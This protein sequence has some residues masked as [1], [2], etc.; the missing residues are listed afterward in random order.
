LENLMFK[1]T[2]PAS[3]PAPAEVGTAVPTEPVPLSVLELD[4]PA[5]TTGWLIE[6]DRRGVDVVVDDIGRDSISKADARQLIAEHRDNEARKARMRAES[7][8]RAI[9]ADQRFRA[10]L[11]VGVPASAIPHGMTY[12]QAI[13]SAE[14]D[15]QA[16]RRRASVVE[17][18]L[19]NDGSLTFHSF[20]P[21]PD[22][23]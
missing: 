14:L 1:T 11:G 19:S 23:D 9:E 17:D 22:E 3:E 2:I 18:L 13:A 12:G 5:P 7:E 16:Y 6:L 21:T 4:L 15:S 20:S 8:K 10:S